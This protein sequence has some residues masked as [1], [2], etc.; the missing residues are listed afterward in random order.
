MT[1]TQGLI[2]STRKLLNET[3]PEMGTEGDTH[4]TDMMLVEVL[5]RSDSLNQALYLLWTQKAGLV[6]NGGEVKSI[7][8]GGETV[9]KYTKGEYVDMCLKTA[10]GY[11]DAWDKEGGSSFSIATMKKKEESLW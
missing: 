6:Q 8:A 3:I 4:F 5:S 2:D 7:T 10:K 11:K 9:Q 1:I